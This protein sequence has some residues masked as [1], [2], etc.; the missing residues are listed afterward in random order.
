MASAGGAIETDIVPCAVIGGVLISF[1]S[2]VKLNA[3]AA[4]GVPLSDPV[5]LTP[6]PGGVLPL[7]TDQV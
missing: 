5:L 2:T 6:S 7:T 1:T 3:P 4:E